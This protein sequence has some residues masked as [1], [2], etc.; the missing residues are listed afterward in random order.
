MAW[1]STNVSP[2]GKSGGN[3]L[4]FSNIVAAANLFTTYTPTSGSE[5]EKLY[6]LGY[7]YKANVPVENCLAVMTPDGTLSLSDVKNAG[8]AIASQIS[9]YDGGICLYA[10]G[11][12]ANNITI[13][14]LELRWSEN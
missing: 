7:M 8:V 12:P 14:N 4:F 11:V 2:R 6:N 10:T 9:C 1:G 13:L 5:E 3:S